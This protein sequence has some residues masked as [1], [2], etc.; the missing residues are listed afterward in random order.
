MAS[1]GGRAPRARHPPSSRWAG[2][3]GPTA[4]PARSGSSCGATPSRLAP[5]SV[6]STDRGPLTVAG[7]RP[8]QDRYLVR[9]VG[10]EDR[11]GAEALRGLLLR[12]APLER[13]PG[14]CGS[15]SSSARPWSSADGRPLGVVAAVEANPASDL[16]VLE[17]G[18]L[19]PL[20]FVVAPRAGGASGGRRPRGPARLR[21]GST[22]SR[23]SPT[24]SRPTA[25]PACS[26]GGRGR[27]V[28]DLRVHD[29]RAG[30][31]R[32]APL[33][34]RR[35]LRRRPR[36]GAHVRAAVRRGRAGRR[37]GRADRPP[38][39]PARPGGAPLRPGGRPGARPA[40]RGSRS[41]C[42]RYEGVDQ[43]VA[44]HLVDGELSVGDVVL[45][46][47]RGRRPRGHRGGGS[48][49]CPGCSATPSRPV[50]ESFADGLLEYPQYTR[51]AEFRGSGRARGAPLGR[52]RGGG[53]VAAGPGAAPHARAGG[54]T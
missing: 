18:G 46:G 17:G 29:L 52:P 31:R 16:L 9:F 11:A 24:S 43:R 3:A 15:T 30:R 54:P 45:A 7:S 4:S 23:S 14:R 38:A 22:S 25:R 35:P 39:P 37:R 21:C 51:P 26:G 1:R 6:L 42:G 10:V 12:A 8:H 32:P 48:A 28:V 36:H 47:R 40:R 34:R 27:G 19:I 2:S 50:E 5:G 49:W 13:G 20:R 53:P 44:D 41:L 33:G